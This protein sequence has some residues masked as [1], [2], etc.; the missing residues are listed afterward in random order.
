[1]NIALTEIVGQF[2]NSADQSTHQF[3]RLYNISK[4]G[5]KTEFNLDITGVLKTALRDV[6]ANKTVSYP[7]DCISYSKIGIKNG[8]GVSLL[9]RNPHLSMV[10]GGEGTGDDSVITQSNSDYFFNYVRGTGYQLFG[11]AGGTPTYGEYTVNEG[12]RMIYLSPD[13]AYSQIVLEYLS[14][15][16]DCDCDEPEVPVQAGSAMVAYV[17]WQDAIDQRKKFS[18][19]AV[20]QLKREFYREKRLA[21]MRINKARLTEIIQAHQ[22]THILLPRI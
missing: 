22:L 11:L 4:F 15:G 16:S 1:M 18:P 21:K 5:M 10:I 3:R 7:D 19:S 17:R 20:N 12:E 2:L 13:F 8:G 14:D 6:S 9:K